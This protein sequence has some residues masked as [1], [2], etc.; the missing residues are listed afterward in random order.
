MRINKYIAQCGAA[1]RREAEKLIL[2]GRIKINN[3][4]VVDLATNVDE[5][6]DTVTLDGNIIRPHT[7]FVYAMFNKHKGCICSV[8]DDRNRKTVMDYL[9]DLK[10]YRVFP[11]GRLDYNT[12]GLLLITNDGSICNKLTHPSNEIPKVYIAKTRGKID[13]D[14]LKELR[15]GI[16]LDGR[17]LSKSKIKLLEEKDDGECK[18]EVT[19]FEGRNRQMHRMFEW[20][21]K[22]VLFLKRVQIGD[23]RLGGL[24][25]GK[26]RYL[27]KKELTYLK[28]I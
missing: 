2:E 7:R 11:V 24:A 4:I 16:M 1:S 5:Y 26:Y 3:K 13:E 27:N 12:E 18:Y 6:N 22:E 23:I 25:R 28:N 9:E 17:K 19:I 15:N 8:K 20:A 21:G 10:D 14:K